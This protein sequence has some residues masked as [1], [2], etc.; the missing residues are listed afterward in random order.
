MKA[1]FKFTTRHGFVVAVCLV[2]FAVAQT[3]SNN[4]HALPIG[5][6][7]GP[8]DQEKLCTKKHTNCKDACD[9]NLKDCEQSVHGNI[10]A[11]QSCYR[12]YTNCISR[13]ND[14]RKKCG[15]VIATTQNRPQR[16]PELMPGPP[17]GAQTDVTSLKAQVCCKQGRSFRLTSPPECRAVKGKIVGRNRCRSA[18]FSTN[19]SGARICCRRGRQHMLS[20]LRDCTAQRGR[21]VN[22]R[23][24]RKR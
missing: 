10:L 14:R 16:Q 8:G 24:C 21:H 13:C 23:H 3:G 11:L 1:I 17:V 20:T 4:V 22:G 9:R 5:D 12:K 6:R 19:S 7:D 15:T 18:E 2:L